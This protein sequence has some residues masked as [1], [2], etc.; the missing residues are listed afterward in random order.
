[1]WVCLC[2]RERAREATPQTMFIRLEG[3][4]TASNHLF[5]LPLYFHL[6]LPLK[7]CLH[8]LLKPLFIL[9]YSHN[10]DPKINTQAAVSFIKRFYLHRGLFQYH[11]FWFQ[12]HKHKIYF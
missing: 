10:L 5:S 6:I 8:R 4:Y 2:E 1:M 7:F 11:I 3:F 12:T 9:H